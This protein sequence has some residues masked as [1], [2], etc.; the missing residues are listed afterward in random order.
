[1]PVYWDRRNSRWRFEFDRKVGDRRRRATKLLPKGWTA[2]QADEFARAEEARLYGVATGQIKQPYPISAAVKLYID[3][4]VKMLKS[5][6]DYERE[7]ANL[8][9]LYQGMSIDQLPEVAQ[10]IMALP[11][12]PATKKNKISYLRAACRYA[13]KRGKCDTNPSDRLTL[14]TVKNERHVYPRRK[15][16]LQTA[17]R[18][19]DK[20]VRAAV[21]VAYYS[22]MRLGE[23]RKADPESGVFWV[24]DTKNGSP[25]AIPVHHKV[26]VYLG[27]IPCKW[28]RSWVSQVFNRHKVSDI[29][30]HDLRHG[31]ASEMINANVP[32]NVVGAVLGHKD[33]K[34]T[35]R[36][37]HL[38]ID[39]LTD[40]VMRI[41]AK[42]GK[43][44]QST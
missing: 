2:D 40:A 28:S 15:E 21:L 20:D 7:F 3:E 35:Q 1:M 29:H 11:V 26:R 13:Y 18:I 14:P 33:H 36:Y 22:G 19:K 10:R 44:T 30:F 5:R 23:I 17:R 41:G 16:V 39:T 8:F 6:D 27:R 9:H 24:A 32:L 38:V 37:A 31:A 34:S 43:S 12:S 42:A 25:R 4:K